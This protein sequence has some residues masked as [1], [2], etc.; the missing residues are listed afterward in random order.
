MSY[1]K[2]GPTALEQSRNEKKL[3]GL[4]VKKLMASYLLVKPFKADN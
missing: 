3:R 2:T 1:K 4:G